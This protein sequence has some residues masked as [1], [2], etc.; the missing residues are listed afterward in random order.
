MFLRSSLLRTYFP[1]Y[2][3]NLS[4]MEYCQCDEKYW[5]MV[6]NGKSTLVNPNYHCIPRTNIRYLDT[7]PV[8][9]N[10][11]LLEGLA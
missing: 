10:E 7:Q 11:A 2:Q 5:I 8:V 9:I 6:K 1:Y 4:M 3:A